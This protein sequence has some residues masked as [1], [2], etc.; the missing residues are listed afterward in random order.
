MKK[1]NNSEELLERIINNNL[2]DEDKNILTNI[3]KPKEKKPKI[4][5]EEMK[6]INNEKRRN[7]YKEDEEYR[8]TIIQKAEDYHDRKMAELG[9]EKSN[10]KTKDL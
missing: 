6:Q 1:I 9:I 8:L 4:P 5:T 7:K 10:R 2:N 3:F